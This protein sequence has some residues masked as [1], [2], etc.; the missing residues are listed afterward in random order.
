M[1]SPA[2]PGYAHFASQPHRPTCRLIRGIGAFDS[3]GPL[4]QKWLRW[5]RVRHPLGGFDMARAKPLVTFAVAALFF[6]G[7]GGGS[8]TTPTAS[9]GQPASNQAPTLAASSAPT[10]SATV[11]V[12]AL[13]SRYSD[14]AA[15]GNAAI[16]QCNKD[17][18]AASGDLTKS[19]VAAQECLTSYTAYAADM[20]AINWGPAQPQAD[21]VIA[22]M[23]K[24][25]LIT[26]QM[27]AAT[28]EAGFMASYQ[29]IA[30][31]AAE[32]LTAANALRSA[33][34]LPPASL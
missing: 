7:C 19:K 9:T 21:K 4:A 30:S 28:T 32:L 14:I 12:A 1:L 34:G 24:I 15:K 29:Q 26:G 27:A 6:A 18:T 16:V 33:L 23:D 5:W 11:D 10:A 22:A 2:R 13:P 8:A 17:K 3:A 20:K 25:D 31:A